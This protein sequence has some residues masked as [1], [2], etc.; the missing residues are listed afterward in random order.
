[1]C[2]KGS[3]MPT[4]GIPGASSS[5]P[6]GQGSQAA[7]PGAI[8][9]TPPPAAPPQTPAPDSEQEEIPGLAGEVRMGAACLFARSPLQPVADMRVCPCRVHS[10]WM[11][12]VP[13]RRPDFSREGHAGSCGWGTWR[14]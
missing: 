13:L 11:L 7:S 12:P 14:R 10:R 5:T 4:Q 8:L 2:L 1:M 3:H 9:S 6:L